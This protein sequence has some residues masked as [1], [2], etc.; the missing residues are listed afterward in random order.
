MC[1]VCDVTCVD[2]SH[3]TLQFLA[4]VQ[5]QLKRH[6]L[7]CHQHAGLFQT[8]CSSSCIGWTKMEKPSELQTLSKLCGLQTSDLCGLAVSPESLPV[9]G[10]YRLRRWGI[11][12][13]QS[14]R[15][16]QCPQPSS[17]RAVFLMLVGKSSLKLLSLSSLSLILARRL[18][19]R[20]LCRRTDRRW[21][22]V[23]WTCGTLMGA[24]QGRHSR[25]LV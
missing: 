10:E 14:L 7:H 1:T 5:L 23:W 8:T 4:L 13:L 15:I 11:N 3:P 19:A 18:A 9:G 17:N 22:C 20:S 6:W 12:V 21:C 16:L 25:E 2:F 24:C